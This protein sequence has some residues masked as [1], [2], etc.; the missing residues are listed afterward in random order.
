[1]LLITL[2][3]IDLAHYLLPD[4][5][6]FTFIINTQYDDAPIN[7]I[8]ISSGGYKSLNKFVPQIF[9]PQD[10]HGL[11]SDHVLMAFVLWE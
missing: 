2:K 3:F 9:N 6:T 8:L 5:L 4:T 7:P 11:L 10:R 1:M